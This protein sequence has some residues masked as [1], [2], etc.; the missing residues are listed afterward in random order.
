M[1]GGSDKIGTDNLRSYE[2]PDRC[3]L[4]RIFD[5]TVRTA[6]SL[7]AG[8]AAVAGELD[9]GLFLWPMLVGAGARRVPAANGQPC[10][11]SY[12][13]GSPLPYF[14]HGGCRL[15]YSDSGR[16]GTFC[17]IC[18]AVDSIAAESGN[19]SFFPVK[20]C[21]CRRIFLPKTAI[22]LSHKNLIAV[23]ICLLCRK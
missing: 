16:F 2:M 15:P 9:A 10:P 19:S 17:R 6:A 5:A 8:T 13:I 1:F 21:D 14:C 20:R 18:A 12:S 22:R 23:L 3:L 7:F 4:G 11:N